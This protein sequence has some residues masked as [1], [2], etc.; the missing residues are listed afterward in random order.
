MPAWPLG[1]RI[2]DFDSML[3]RHAVLQVLLIKICAFHATLQFEF[4]WSACW[5][6]ELR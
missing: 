6:D 2:N 4:V 3:Q 5:L 1:L